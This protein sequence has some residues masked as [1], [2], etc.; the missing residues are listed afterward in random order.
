MGRR[1]TPSRVVA[2]CDGCGGLLGDL[3]PGERRHRLCQWA[4]AEDWAALRP[5]LNGTFLGV[6]ISGG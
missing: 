6:S 1:S 2:D 4:T 3:A 5:Y